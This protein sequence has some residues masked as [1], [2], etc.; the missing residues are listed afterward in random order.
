MNYYDVLGVTKGSSVSD[1]KSAYRKLALKW[2][3]DKNKSGE[4]EKKFKEINEAYEIL[5]DG[6]KR[7]LYDQVGHD[8][9]KRSGG[10]SASG[11]ASGY[12]GQGFQYYTNMGGRG[13][14]FDFGGLDPF[15]IFEQ[16]FG[17]RSPQDG[18]RRQRRASYEMNLTFIEAVRGV[19]KR[20]V[21]N[22]KEKTIKVPAGVDN[23]T[24]IR[25][26]DF[27][28]VVSV[29][30]DSE[31]RREGQDIYLVHEL[32]IAQAVL[33]DIVTVK[34]IDNE[35]KLR[36]K[37]GTQ[38]GTMTRLRGQG[39]PYPNTNQRGDQYV[40]WKISVPHNISGKA[41]KLFEELKFEL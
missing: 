1:I 11:N 25:F 8:S 19:T 41:R 15:D 31:F 12:P 17:F 10:A 24:K 22:G 21:I 23:G 35:V 36:V 28:V 40:V 9:F 14:E 2:H 4:A 13:V 5:S 18:A 33:G 16:F 39:V 38:H 34:T 32:N 30:Q 26:S 3:P 20:T 7:E 37:P 6:S 27:D 29:S